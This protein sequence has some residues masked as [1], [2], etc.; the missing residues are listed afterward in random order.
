LKNSSENPPRPWRQSTHHLCLSGGWI[1]PCWNPQTDMS[2]SHLRCP[3]SW[4]STN[5]YSCSHWIIDSG[6]WGLDLAQAGLQTK[7]SH[8]CPCSP[9]LGD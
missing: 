9:N 6:P 5:S 4:S 1:H 7:P 2:G 8:P 3:L